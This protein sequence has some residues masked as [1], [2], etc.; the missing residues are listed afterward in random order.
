MWRLVSQHLDLKKQHDNPLSLTN[1]VPKS[2]APPST[3][4]PKL[5]FSSTAE[6]DP[7]EIVNETETAVILWVEAEMGGLQYTTSSSSCYTSGTPMLHKQVWKA[8]I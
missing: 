2:R 6:S 8:I 1:P 7:K 5:S 4:I 3:L